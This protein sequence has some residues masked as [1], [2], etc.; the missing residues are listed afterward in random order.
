MTDRHRVR[1]KFE[2]RIL[3]QLFFEDKAQ[4]IGIILNDKDVLF[5][6]IDEVFNDEKVPNPYSEDDFSIDAAR[7][8]ESVLML[9][10]IF[11]E[12]EEEPLCYCSYLFFD[13]KFEKLGYF[14]IEKGNEMSDF[15]PFVCSWTPEGK[16]VKHVNYGN[17]TFEDHNDFLRCA[18]IF[19]ENEFGLTRKS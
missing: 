10:I 15:Y 13:D 18:D 19:M 12:P 4:F 3:P 7:I 5:R 9:K 17:C 6:M 1:Y 2:H 16:R 8:T 11:P 14:C